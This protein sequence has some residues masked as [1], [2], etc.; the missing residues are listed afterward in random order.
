[1]HCILSRLYVGSKFLPLSKRVSFFKFSYW[2]IIIYYLRWTLVYNTLEFSGKVHVYVY[3][4]VINILHTCICICIWK[5]RYIN[6]SASFVITCTFN[7]YMYMYLY[8][9]VY[10]AY[11]T[12]T[13]TV[14]YSDRFVAMAISSVTP[15]KYMHFSGNYY[16]KIA[17]IPL[18]YM[19]AYN[20]TIKNEF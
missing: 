11:A 1:M 3:V 12:K 4:L 15:A 13:K 20:F 14:S 18:L 9:R 10:L 6:C 8:G 2:I 5:K 7:M 19:Y 16:F 17:M